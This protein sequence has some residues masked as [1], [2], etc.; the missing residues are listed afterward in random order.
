[1]TSFCQ[2]QTLSWETPG[3]DFRLSKEFRIQLNLSIDSNSSPDTLT[4][5]EV[6]YLKGLIQD[7]KQHLIML[8]KKTIIWKNFWGKKSK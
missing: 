3:C 1:M 5:S 2:T 7:L 8:P 6:A 4:S